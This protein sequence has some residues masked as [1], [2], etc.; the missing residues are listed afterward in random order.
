MLEKAILSDRI[1]GFAQDRSG[2]R[3]HP[4]PTPGD[5]SG[6]GQCGPDRIMFDRRAAHAAAHH[7]DTTKT[8]ERM[9]CG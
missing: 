1:D 2:R 4:P 5:L 6:G 3:P 8:R 9:R 7:R